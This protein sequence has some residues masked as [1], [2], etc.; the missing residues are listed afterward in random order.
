[1]M[2]YLQFSLSHILLV[3]LVVVFSLGCTQQAKRD[4][5]QVSQEAVS[6]TKKIEWTMPEDPAAATY[7]ENCK[8]DYIK[9]EEQITEFSLRKQRYQT[10]ILLNKMNGIYLLLE[11]QMGYASL[12]ANVHP[13]PAMR[14]AAELC[15]QNFVNL[16]TEISLSRPL[17]NHVVKININS[18]DEL[19]KRLVTRTLNDFK[20]SGVDKSEKVRE[21]IRI[22]NN[23]ITQ[24]GQVFDKNI[25]EGSRK[26]VLNSVTDL[27][28]LPKDYIDAHKPDA[29]GKITLTTAYPDYY[30]FMQY[31]END[32]LRKQFYIVFRQ[33]GY[34]ENKAVLQQLLEKRFELANLL[35]YA[36]YADYITQDKMIKTPSNA[37]DF[38]DKVSGL[39]TLRAQAEYNQLLARLQKINPTATQVTDWQKL[40]LEDLVKK[41]SYQVNAQEVRQ[42]FQ[43]A[44]VRKGIFDLTEALFGVTIRPW[45]TD[46]WHPSVES[47]EMLDGDKIIGRFHLDMHPRE[48]KYK[49]AA[50]IG[51]RSGLNGVQ[52]PEAALVCNF[53]G[54]DGGLGLMEHSEVETFLHEFGHLLH[55]IFAG[56]NQRWL[57]FS[58][59]KTEWD[60]VEAPSQML[61]EWVWDADTLAT[62]ARNAKGQIIPPALVKKMQTA[63]RFGK[64]SWTKH[65]LFYAALSLNLYKQNPT[66]L[67]IDKMMKDIQSQYSPYGYVDDTYFYASFGHLNGY[68]AIYYTY[69]WSLV[70][71]ADMHSEFVKHGLRNTDV[72]M[73]YRKKVLEPGGTQDAADLVQDFL[74]RPY[75]FDAFASDLKN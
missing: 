47:Y 70:I 19:D 55:S 28:G 43:Y 17:Y 58:G 51:F 49:H 65:Q 72:A 26:L 6:E 5:A 52:L 41:E 38:I 1:M 9:I 27:K 15:E 37:Q 42:Y 12:Y 57:Y 7:L 30:P 54:G 32:E 69:M 8:A 60:F 11:N 23:E 31:A 61:E 21:R 22:L 20:R 16:I 40:Y 46:V 4:E 39:A 44:N 67:D 75:S 50:H 35:G 14:S 48:G 73:R 2:N 29:E 59:I 63:R 53:P 18:L 64:G 36:N 13:N 3:F 74:E 71:A 62:F 45:K 25:R 24:I 66:T 68:S 34:P 56:T 33:Q 10:P